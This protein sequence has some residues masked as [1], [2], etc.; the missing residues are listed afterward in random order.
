MFCGNCGTENVSSAIYCKECGAKLNNAPKQNVDT[1]NNKINDYFFNTIATIKQLPKKILIGGIAA[2]AVLL[3]IICVAITSSSKINLNKYVVINSEG[4]D[5]YGKVSVSVDWDAIEK[6]YGK[7]VKFAGSKSE[8]E[9]L[10][11]YSSPIDAMKD[12]VSVK[13]EPNSN[14]SNGDKVEYTWDIDEDLYK[15]I[16]CKIKYKDGEYKVSGL[17]KLATFDAFSDLTVEF[18]GIAP[19]GTANINYTGSDLDYFDFSCDKTT[20]LS[21]GDVVKVTIDESKIEAIVDRLGKIPET[22]EKEF[23]VEGLDSYLLKVDEI[24]SDSLEKMQKQAEDVFNALAAKNWGDGEELQTLT[25]VGNYLLTI[26]ESD[27]WNDNNM[28]YLVYKAQ[29]RNFFSNS[30]KS[31]DQVNDI[32]WFISY[33]DLKVDSDG[34]TIVDVS[35][36]GIP[37]DRVEIDSGISVWWSNKTWYYYAYK[38]I[39]ELYKAVVTKNLDTYNHQDNI[40]ENVAPKAVDTGSAL[41]VEGDYKIAD[42][43]TR[44]ITYADLEG[45]SAEDCKIARNEIYAR[46]GRKFQD[47]N[48]QNY[49]NQLEWYNGTI[50]PDAF[51]ESVLS[52]VEI[53]NKDTIVKFEAEKGYK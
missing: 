10:M 29:V 17:T 39:D 46:H 2:L 1:A 37:N 27:S 9:D 31:Y 33:S 7:K 44:Q 5:R 19:N 40:D 16:K 41:V 25:Y 32:Y 6:K 26:K 12:F 20:E 4:Y 50:E 49:F 11:L 15:L 3:I 24:D 8:Y 53:A 22:N 13:I 18:S 38:S 42:S 23:T 35:E 51:D 48:L 43:D 52:D 21:N 47:E 28:L 14:L 45:F 30:D 34:N 36:Y